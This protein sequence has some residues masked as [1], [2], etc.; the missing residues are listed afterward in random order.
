[1]SKFRGVVTTIGVVAMLS[2][3][4]AS[5]AAAD[6]SSQVTAAF[7]DLTADLTPTLAA[8]VVVG[9]GIIAL[10]IG[11]KLTFKGARKVG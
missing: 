9:L 2:L 1:M 6:Y 8:I 7:T 3:T 10:F 11:V 4:A 5:V